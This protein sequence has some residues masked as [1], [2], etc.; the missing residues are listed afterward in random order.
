MNTSTKYILCFLMVTGVTFLVVSIVMADEYTLKNNI[1]PT[2]I[3]MYKHDNLTVELNSTAYGCPTACLYN[4]TIEVC[5]RFVK[6]T[7][8]V[9][10]FCFCVLASVSCAM[11]CAQYA[12]KCEVEDLSNYN[13]V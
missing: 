12:Y 3:C 8:L 11:L 13:I 6:S 9:S 7:Y 1:K 2:T 10:V 5:R 4:N